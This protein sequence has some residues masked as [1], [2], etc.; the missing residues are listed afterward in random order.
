MN[1]LTCWLGVSGVLFFV[2]SAI[3]GSL[4]FPE[5][6][7]L[8]QYISET[9]AT[10]TP[11]GKALRYVGY[12]PSG[13]FLTAFALLAIKVLPSSSMTKLGFS[14]FGIFYGLVTI[15][16]AIFP[17]DPGCNRE[18]IDPSTSQVIHNLAGFSTYVLVPPALIVIGFAAKNWREAHHVSRWAIF[19]GVLSGVVVMVL[20]SDPNSNYV[21]L[22]QRIIELSILSWVIL[23]AVYIKNFNNDKS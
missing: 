4:Q 6:S 18:W 12:V 9:Y 17:C 2:S 15:V 16:V 19:A 11:Y 7:H 10:G 22:F 1:K 8:S 20:I 13:I 23:C 3:V 14:G 21:G 5:Y